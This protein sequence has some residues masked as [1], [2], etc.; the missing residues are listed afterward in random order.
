MK[1]LLLA[2]FMFL[3]LNEITAHNC[4]I[5]V[6]PSL[7]EKYITCKTCDI[8]IC[9]VS[10]ICEAGDILAQYLLIDEYNINECDQCG[11]NKV[12]VYKQ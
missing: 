10:I 8:D 1:I 6:N 9:P 11:I 7:P 2:M 5:Y 4:C 3:I 12:K